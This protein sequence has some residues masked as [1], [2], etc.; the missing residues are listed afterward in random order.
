M[1]SNIETIILHITI[2]AQFFLPAQTNPVR[3]GNFAAAVTGEGGK[4]T[5][6]LWH[7][8]PGLLN[9]KQL[10]RLPTLKII[11]RILTGQPGGSV[12]QNESDRLSV[13]TVIKGIS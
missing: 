6:L 2:R 4:D 11:K 10:L 7:N 9:I 3:T 13:L 1:R 8:E 5:S 12:A